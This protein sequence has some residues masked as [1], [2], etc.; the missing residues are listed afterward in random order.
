MNIPAPPADDV[1]YGALA[2]PEGCAPA[3]CPPLREGKII[4]GRAGAAAGQ[5]PQQV[6][7]QD[8]AP[9]PVIMQQ[10]AH[11][12]VESIPE[13][14]RQSLAQAGMPVEKM[15]N[16]LRASVRAMSIKIPENNNGGSGGSPKQK[17]MQEILMHTQQ[18]Y[19]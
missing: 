6:A 18:I 1:D 5:T 2:A 13:A 4:K 12:P 17:S 16:T 3:Y 11:V 10:A 8:A 7:G 9:A 14:V 15:S 19:H